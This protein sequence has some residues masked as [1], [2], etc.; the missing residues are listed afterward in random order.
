MDKTVKLKP[1]PEMTMAE[2]N[3]WKHWAQDE[4]SE[5]QDFTCELNEELLERSYLDIKKR[6]NKK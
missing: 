1:L 4:I 2:L 5:Y 6:V 3:D